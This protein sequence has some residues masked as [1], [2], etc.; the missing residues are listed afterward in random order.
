MSMNLDVVYDVVLRL[1]GSINPVGS[2]EIDEDRFVNLKVMTE[3]IDKLVTD[4]FLVGY[5]NRTASA[6]SMKRAADFA[7][8]F[9]GQIQRTI[10]ESGLEVK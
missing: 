10:A 4:V 5:E 6:I 8:K 9:L 7:Y 1:I 3:L 2:L